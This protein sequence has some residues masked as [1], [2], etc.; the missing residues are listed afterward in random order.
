MKTIV[1]MLDAFRK[2]Y[3]SEENT[4]FLYSLIKKYGL[5]DLTPPFGFK[6]TTGFYTGFNPKSL[7]LFTS[8]IY[9][10][11]S[12]KFS[13]LN[14]SLLS[15]L[16]NNPAFSLINLLRHFKGKDIFLPKIN[17]NCLAYFNLM[18]DK[19]F[20]QENIF[21]VKTLFD[22]FRE[23][24][25][26]YL[27]YDFPLIIENSKSR[28]HYTLKNSDDSRF[29]KF[30][31]LMKKDYDFYY[32]HFVDLDSIGHYK[33]T[34]SEELKNHLKKLDKMVEF[35]L[36]KFN[37]EEDNILLWSDHGMVD[38]KNTLD[39]KS[40]LPEFGKGYIYFLDSTMARFWFFNKEKR[41]EVLDILKNIKRG[42]I[43]N[44]EDKK[45][46]EIDFN[47]NLYGDEIFLAN[48]GTLICPNFFQKNPCKGM[49]G[50]DLS[51]KNEKTF[52][53][54]N[55]KKEKTKNKAEMKD[56]FSTLLEM[57]N[58]KIPENIKGKSLL[59]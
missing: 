52:F 46:L 42:R 58:L 49:H 18:Q 34:N 23:N 14:L 51:D 24:N 36:S 35:I 12:R 10:K 16:S 2:D 43:L 33:G 11:N 22:I 41:K 59:R 30:L 56:L 6:T 37:L 26:K 50:Y 47:H 1:I 13:N 4:P 48:S 39:I 8:Y 25:I 29:E 9:E 15:F 54:I 27:Y 57:M 38:I 3:F 55:R 5:G 44:K 21:Q 28:I 31:G 45:K 40:K 19:H 20:Y 7:N 17:L 32:V 53:I